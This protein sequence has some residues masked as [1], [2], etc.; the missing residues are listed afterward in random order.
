M[1]PELMLEMFQSARILVRGTVL[2]IRDDDSVTV[3][4]NDGDVPLSCDVLQTGESPLRLAE[5]DSVL[6]WC[7]DDAEERGIILG[8][9]GLSQAQEQD[10]DDAPDELVLRAGQRLV[11]SCGEASII[12]REDGKVLVKGKNIVTHATKLNRLR[13][14]AVAIN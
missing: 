12:L 11:L 10:E 4:A 1:T 13:G 3:E 7:S 6:L 2:D 5:G 14:G 8:R 9:I